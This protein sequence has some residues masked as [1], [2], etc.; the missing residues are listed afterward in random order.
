MHLLAQRG[1]WDNLLANDLKGDEDHLGRGVARQFWDELSMNR[2]REQ[3]LLDVEGEWQ[4]GRLRWEHVKRSIQ[5]YQS[6]HESCL[7]A[8]S[9][10]TR[11]CHSQ[12]VKGDARI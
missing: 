11:Y 2:L 7:P 12:N 9:A 10:M 5:Q 1:W 8:P 6:K 3:A 4:A